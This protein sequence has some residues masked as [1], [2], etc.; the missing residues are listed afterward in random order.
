MELDLY[1]LKAFFTVCRLKSFTKAG[2]FLLISQSAISYSVKKLEERLGINLINRERR[3]FMLTPQGER[4]YKACE[5]V[6]YQLETTY[7][8]LEIQKKN[9]SVQIMI[10]SQVE[11]GNTILLKHMAAFINENPEISV[12]F[13]FSPDLLPKLL[14]NELDII[15]D[16][17]IHTDC[18]LK[19]DYLF[20]E[21]YAAAAT[22]AY[23]KS[24][25]IDTIQD[26]PRATILSLDKGLEWWKNFFQAIPQKLSLIEPKKIIRINNIRGLINGAIS[27]MGI[28]FFPV[29]TILK[30]LHGKQ[31]EIA[32]SEIM[33]IDD[34]FNIY[35][36][37]QRAELPS[38]RLITA[39]LKK[40]KL[41]N[42][43]FS[44]SI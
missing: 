38:H 27:G 26:L 19:R 3:Q 43:G 36:K 16:C 9:P 6:F 20:R 10:G 11:F 12:D 32:F 30:E 44:D 39:Y 8:E 22:P 15:I 17:K 35:Q 24:N 31:L 21:H 41:K 4:L 5:K 29:Y 18:S 42:L 1:Q 28:G 23:L 13:H 14:S 37:E 40:L 2:E 25:K 7:E 34:Q 33:P